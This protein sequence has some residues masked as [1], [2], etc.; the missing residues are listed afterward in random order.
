MKIFVISDPHGY[1]VNIMF[2]VDSDRNI[3]KEY[4]DFCIN[5]AREIGIT[6]NP[7]WLDTMNY[8]VSDQTNT[9][10]AEYLRRCKKY[11]KFKIRYPMIKFVKEILKLEEI[12]FDE[13]I[14]N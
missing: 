3:D 4:Q 5:K 12:D 1:G 14:F 9:S 2:K 13:S 7:H 8:E 6:I 10:K 11:D